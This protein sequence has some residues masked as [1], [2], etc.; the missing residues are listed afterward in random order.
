LR[1]RLLFQVHVEY[2]EILPRVKPGVVVH[3]HDIF[4]PGTLAAFAFFPI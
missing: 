1:L 4:L 3:I 2:L